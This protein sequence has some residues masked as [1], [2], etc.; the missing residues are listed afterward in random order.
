[1]FWLNWVIIVTF[2]TVGIVGCI[3]TVGHIAIDAN[4]YKLFANV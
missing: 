4:N 3:A 1:M 2:T